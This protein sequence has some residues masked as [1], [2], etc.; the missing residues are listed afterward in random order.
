MVQRAMR[1]LSRCGREVD[2]PTNEATV[3]EVGGA[4][5]GQSKGALVVRVLETQPQRTVRLDSVV[6]VACFAGQLLVGPQ[7][8]SEVSGSE[9][10]KRE[11]TSEN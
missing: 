1:A 7:A 5:E 6:S 8:A 4:E 11:T 9:Y 2:E 10:S 3:D